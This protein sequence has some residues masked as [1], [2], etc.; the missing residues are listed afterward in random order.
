M[1]LSDK[2]IDWGQMLRDPASFRTDPRWASHLQGFDSGLEES[3]Q[4]SRSEGL[5]HRAAYS[6][7]DASPLISGEITQHLDDPQLTL[8]K[9]AHAEL[10]RQIFGSA[11]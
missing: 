8:E 7:V 5:M 10:I 9:K 1:T 11:P 4:F 6:A 2:D 3:M